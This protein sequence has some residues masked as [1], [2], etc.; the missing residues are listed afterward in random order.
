VKLTAT[1]PVD[2]FS[3]DQLILDVSP[4]VDPAKLDLSNYDEF[5]SEVSVGRPYHRQAVEATIRLVCGGRYENTSELARESYAKSADLQRRYASED[6]L[7]GQLPFPEMLACS[8][9]LAT[10]TGKSFVYHS[11]ARICLNENLVDR[12]LVLCPSLTIEEGLKEKFSDLVANK[13]LMDLLPLRPRGIPLPEIVDAASTVKEGQICIENIHATYERTSSSINDSFA[14]QGERTLV[15]SDEA[16]HIYSPSGKQQK[17]WKKFLLNEDF[18]FRYHVGGSGTC[19]IK[20]DYF[21]DVIYRYPIRQAID[22]RWVK[23]VYYLD[24]DDSSTNHERFQKLRAQHEKNRKTYKPLKPLTIAVTQNI[25][26]A[27]RLAEDLTDFLVEELRGGRNEAETRV[28]IVT[29]DKKHARNVLALEAVDSADSPV[30]WIVSVSMLS[31][32]WDVQ[33]VF[34][35]YPHEKKA[36]NSK[37]LVAQV[38]GRGLR[39]P[40]EL[41]KKGIQALVYVFNHEKW[42]PEIEELVAEVLDAETT[43]SQRPVDGRAAPHFEI[44]TLE[45]QD[46]PTG[47]TGVKVEKPAAIRRIDLAPQHDHA[48]TTTFVSA[49]DRTRT[50]VLITQVVERRYTVEQVVKEVRSRLLQH[51]RALGGDLAKQ[52]PKKNVEKLITDSLGRLRDKS[53]DVTQENSTRI[54]SAFGSRLQRTLK[55][56]AELTTKPIGLG[57]ISTKT[58]RP[59]TERISGLTSNLGLYYD[60]ESEKVG[61]ADDAAA[62]KNALEITVPTRMKPVLN[63]FFFKSPVNVVL[64]QF[65]PEFLFVARLMEE[66]T[67]KA[68][69]SWVKAPDTGFYEIEFSYKN[70]PA[71]KRKSSFFNPDFFLLLELRDEVI[72]VETKADNDT[73]VINRGKLIAAEEHFTAVNDFLKKA[74]KRRRYQF[75]FLSPSSYDGFFDALRKGQLRDYT[76]ELQ[77]ALRNGD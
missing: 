68:L 2:Q 50:D 71:S 10:G 52:Y 45:T 65:K 48:E 9:D 72:V 40:P 77:G 29:S 22:D 37:L 20:N 35:I 74:R 57:A 42:G 54:L 25:K 7:I 21:S 43:I 16:H 5:L 3:A 15:I 23:E 8:L 75:H 17:E 61:T 46:V 66:P 19:W 1:L 34:Q 60:A 53:G 13:D 49:S 18:G 32:G 39:Q 69:K 58:M 51:D 76:S 27:E 55:P 64:T 11:I 70:T 38:L 12:V 6:K 28:L 47:I 36:F 33:N 41:D 44:H 73:S 62:L 30:E 26:A 31:E 59:V 4:T 24:R 63:S 14:G 67:A 56:G